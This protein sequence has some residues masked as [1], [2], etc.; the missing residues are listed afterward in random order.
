MAFLIHVLTES[1]WQQYWSKEA[2]QEALAI[3][4]VKENAGLHKSDGG[5][6]S[7]K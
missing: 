7:A 5:G 3:M 1:L 6:G 2:I 4:D